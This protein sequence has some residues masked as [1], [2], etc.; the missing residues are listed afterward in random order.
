VRE[1]DGTVALA[2]D[3]A[4]QQVRCHPQQRERE[5]EELRCG[6]WWHPKAQPGRPSASHAL[7]RASSEVYAKLVT[8]RLPLS[9]TDDAHFTTREAVYAALRY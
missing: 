7:T 8:K 1:S 4:T 2:T 9:P 6:S 5:R 3:L